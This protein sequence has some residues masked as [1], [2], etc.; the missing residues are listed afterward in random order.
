MFV[1]IITRRN[2]EVCRYFKTLKDAYDFR[3]VLR[4]HK[5]VNKVYRHVT[6]KEIAHALG[7]P[8]KKSKRS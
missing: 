3:K 4:K 5:F 7:H 8:R 6:E 1:V 2:A